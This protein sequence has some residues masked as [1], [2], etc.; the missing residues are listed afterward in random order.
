MHAKTGVFNRFQLLVVSVLKLGVLMYD[1]CGSS[2]S[3]RRSLTQRL[4]ATAP[5]Q[6]DSDRVSGS[7]VVALEWSR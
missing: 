6:N 5:P 2:L 3:E 1:L 4:V 7:G